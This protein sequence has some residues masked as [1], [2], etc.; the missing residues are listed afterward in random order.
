[1]NHTNTATNAGLAQLGVL[2]SYEVT[3]NIAT[4]KVVDDTTEFSQFNL[5]DAIHPDFRSHH[6][7]MYH[8]QPW[9]WGNNVVNMELLRGLQ[10]R[11][12][13]RLVKMEEKIEAKPRPPSLS[14]F[15]NVM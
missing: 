13:S 11:R 14:E 9:P 5:W 4:V 15:K 1:M 10:E 12:L 3:R 7:D 8:F 2:N 6:F